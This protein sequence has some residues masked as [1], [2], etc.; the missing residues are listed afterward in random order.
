MVA[1]ISVLALGGDRSGVDVSLA[2]RINDP[3]ER[4]IPL[5]R[6]GIDRIGL[7]VALLCWMYAWER[8]I[9]A[10]RDIGKREGSRSRQRP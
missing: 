9:L 1:P 2:R 4:D 5:D 6:L 8:V 3:L 7:G 10:S